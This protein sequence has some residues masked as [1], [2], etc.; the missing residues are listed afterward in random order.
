MLA[1][2]HSAVG[3]TLL[4]KQCKNHHFM[5]L[6]C[7]L[8]LGLQLTLVAALSTCRLYSAK[9]T[10]AAAVAGTFVTAAGFGGKKVASKPSDSIELSQV[11]V[12]NLVFAERWLAAVDAD[13]WTE[14]WPIPFPP[15]YA[16]P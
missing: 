6:L 14:L 15:K 3:P 16:L 5:I 7:Y 2:L 12:T 9:K 10:S 8:K 11:W 4:P 1:P 13:R